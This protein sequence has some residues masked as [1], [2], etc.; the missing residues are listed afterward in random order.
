MG[1][2]LC[3]EQ[4]DV[5]NTQRDISAGLGPMGYKHSDVFSCLLEAGDLKRRHPQHWLL[6][7]AAG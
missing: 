6:Q 5:F 7:E 2:K 3:S 1:S 4:S